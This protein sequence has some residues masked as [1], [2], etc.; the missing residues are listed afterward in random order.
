MNRTGERGEELAASHLREEGHEILA[1]NYRF[2]RAEVDLV[3]RNA[4]ELVFVEVKTRRG[5]G[6]G[7]PEEAVTPDKQAQLTKAARGYL[8]EHDRPDAACRFDVVAVLLTGDEPPTI[9]HFR[10]AFWAK[11]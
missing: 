8:H 3:S 5:L 6:F 4:D 1:R 11:E 10:D 2:D 7:R 9:R